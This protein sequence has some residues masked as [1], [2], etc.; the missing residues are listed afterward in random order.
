MWDS[1]PRIFRP[2]RLLLGFVLVWFSG[3]LAIGVKVRR[4]E[5]NFERRDI[6]S[7][8][9]TCKKPPSFHEPVE[10]VGQKFCQWNETSSPLDR[11]HL[12]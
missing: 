1:V 10:T 3:I 4:I 2:Y 11:M 5:I 9:L 8:A 12:S 6:Q 7:E